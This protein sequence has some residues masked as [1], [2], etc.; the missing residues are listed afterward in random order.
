M[1]QLN[2][3]DVLYDEFK[4]NNRELKIIETFAGYGSQSL[5]LKYMGVR[6]KHH[7]ICE[8]SVNSIIAYAD[9]HRNELENYG[10]DYSKD[11]DTKQI[12][13]MLYEYGVS[14]DYNK[15]A[16][17]SQLQRLNEAKL[18]LTYN[19]IKWT[20]NLVDISR[21]SGKDLEIKDDG[22][23][24]L[25]TYSF[26]C[27]DLSIGGKKAGLVNGNRSS[28]LYQVE[29]IL[30]E[31]EHKPHILLLENVNQIHNQ[32]NNIHFKDFQ[33][34]LERLGYSNYWEDLSALDYGIPQTRTRTF[35][36]SILGEYN[37]RFPK[38]TKLNV[39]LDQIV[40]KNV[41]KKYY[42]SKQQVEDIEKWN[43][44]EKPLEKME[45]ISK[46]NLSPTITTRT[47]EYTSSMILIDEEKLIGTY[48]YAQSEQFRPGDSREHVGKNISGTI[49]ASG[50]Q[51]GLII[52]KP[53][54][55]GGVGDKKSNNGTQYY[56][57]DRVYDGN[58]AVAVTTVCNPNYKIDTHYRRLTPR[59]C[60]RLMGVK[61]AD[62]DLI[63]E[64]QNNPS[65]FHLAGDSIV[66][67]VLLALI[68]QFYD[69]IDWKEK[70]KPNEWWKIEKRGNY[71]K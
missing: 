32:E 30:G 64:H 51:N 47:A 35:M 19:S 56:F 25:L 36:V 43:A 46:K 26:P 49:L 57:Q 4:I 2:L 9:L 63:M 68:S 20:N 52:Q 39:F 17:L 6:F 29:R 38:I 11:F 55:I 16:S 48:D 21:V 70:Y 27:Q 37:Y 12:I 22:A 61:D 14:L 60:F 28:L 54:V 24:Y 65:A 40:E 8:W 34:R 66:T 13:N 3:F 59:E 44:Y 31:C 71:G 67:T 10:K 7:K 45:E 33:L 58:V 62:I 1:E 42:L 18:R 15:P 50:N 69:D 5:S 41:D 53:R 23:I